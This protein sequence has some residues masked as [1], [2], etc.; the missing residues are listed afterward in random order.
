VRLGGR[1]RRCLTSAREWGVCMSL[2][3]RALSAPDAESRGSACEAIESELSLAHQSLRALSMGRSM[4]ERNG[5][6]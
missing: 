3:L 4:I 6:S 1:T 2:A 5:P